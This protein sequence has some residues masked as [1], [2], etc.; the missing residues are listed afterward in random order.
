M[1]IIL[2]VVLETVWEAFTGSAQLE[3]GIKERVRRKSVTSTDVLLLNE[4]IVN[5]ERALNPSN[6]HFIFRLSYK[7]ELNID[8]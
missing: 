7:Y 5:N 2:P 8:F 1:P 3:N 4:D 6:R